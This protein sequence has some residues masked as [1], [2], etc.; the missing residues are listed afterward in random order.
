[1]R[2]FKLPT[3][4][5]PDLYI[6]PVP[7]KLLQQQGPR[8]QSTILDSSKLHRATTCPQSLD[9]IK[10]E[11]DPFL[12]S[13]SGVNV[14]YSPAPKVPRNLT[15]VPTFTEIAWLRK[16]MTKYS[17]RS[18]RHRTCS[19]GSRNVSAGLCSRASA[20]RRKQVLIL[21]S[22]LSLRIWEKRRKTIQKVMSR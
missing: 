13:A 2:Q 4:A 22:R 21:H 12:S 14:S 10:C 7:A 17:R 1:M 16:T 9:W 5:M 6:I 15:S 20:E 8:A 11:P 19:R 3:T 18:R